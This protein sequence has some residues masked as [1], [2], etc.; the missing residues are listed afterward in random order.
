MSLFLF[1]NQWSRCLYFKSLIWGSMTVLYVYRDEDH[2]GNFL[3]LGCFCYCLIWKS[4]YIAQTGLKLCSLGWPQI[5]GDSPAS[6]S[7]LLRLQVWASIP[8]CQVNSHHPFSA[9]LKKLL[10]YIIYSNGFHYDIFTQ[11]YTLSK[12]THC[13]HLLS[14]SLLLQI[15]F[16]P[17]L[18]FFM[19]TCLFNFQM[20]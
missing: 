16:F 1:F 9:P 2:K 11:V 14:S 15:L 19:Q 4:Q 3:L 18:L 8:T 5:C 20:S 7:P 10:A 13:Y 6:V 17:T 12:F